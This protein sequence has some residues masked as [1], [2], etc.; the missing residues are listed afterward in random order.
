[1]TPAKSGA[2]PLNRGLGSAKSLG[3]I[4]L[5]SRSL[6]DGA[7]DIFGHAGPAMRLATKRNVAALSVAIQVVLNLRPKKQML[8]IYARRRV[9]FMENVHPFWD[10]ATV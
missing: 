8:R 2:K 9:A 4:T 1:M 7:D 10:G 3:D 6:S 5:L